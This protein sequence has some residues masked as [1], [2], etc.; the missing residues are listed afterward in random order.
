MAA[1]GRKAVGGRNPALRAHRRLKARHRAT[2]EEQ[3]ENLAVRVHRSLS[4]LKRAADCKDADGRLIFFWIA[5]NAAYAKDPGHELE[6]VR[7][8]EPDVFKRFFRKLCG[9]DKD[10]KLYSLLTSK[11]TYKS[12]EALLDNHY[13]SRDFWEYQRGNITKQEWDRRTN[14]K[15]RDVNHFI[16]DYNRAETTPDLTEGNGKGADRSPRA[17]G[18]GR[19]R[20]NHARGGN[21]K[22]ADRSPRERS[23]K[24]TPFVLSIV[25]S[26]IYVLRNQLVHGGATWN[27]KVNREQIRDCVRFMEKFVIAMLEI[28]VEDK[29]SGWDDVAYPVVADGDE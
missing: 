9:L 6:R 3:E 2:R 21:R 10:N 27:G 4:W 1:T 12:I 13:I 29:S 11:K 19:Q 25:F 22:G 16:K 7:L 5:F 26:R 14:E 28:L 17:A 24:D 20:A 18:R 8:S 23:I 15:R